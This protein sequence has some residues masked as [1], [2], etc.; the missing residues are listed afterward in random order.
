MQLSRLAESD[1]FGRDL[2]TSLVSAFADSKAAA[3]LSLSNSCYYR[4]NVFLQ[5]V[6]NLFSCVALGQIDTV[7]TSIKRSPSVFNLAAP[8]RAPPPGLWRWRKVTPGSRCSVFS[9]GETLLLFCSHHPPKTPCPWK[10]PSGEHASA[11]GQSSLI[12][13]AVFFFFL[14]SFALCT[15]ITITLEKIFFGCSCS[16]F[17]SLQD[18]MHI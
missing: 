11:P 5:L 10:S 9:F 2:E 4:W 15:I 1:V 8:S 17:F 7:E 13:E 18:I 3:C 6:C 16:K 14:H 12:T